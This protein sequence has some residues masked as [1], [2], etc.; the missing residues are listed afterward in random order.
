MTRT[1]ATITTIPAKVPAIIGTEEDTF[2]SVGSESRVVV[3]AADVEC[4]IDVAD[5]IAALFIGENNPVLAGMEIEAVY[6][7]DLQTDADEISIR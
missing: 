5:D 2:G 6:D 3:D 4:K 7:V 1:V